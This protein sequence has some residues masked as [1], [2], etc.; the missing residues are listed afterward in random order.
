MKQVIV[1]IIVIGMTLGSVFAMSS[2]P[3][4]EIMIPDENYKVRIIDIDGV[5]TIGSFMTFEC[6]TFVSAKRGATVIFIPFDRIQSIRM[7]NNSDVITRELPEIEMT[8]TLTDGSEYESLAVSREEFT[9]QAGFGQFRIRT[10]HIRSIEFLNDA[11]VPDE[12]SGAMP[13]N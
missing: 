1:T 10:D 8:V 7:K 12:A 11:A 13:A 3:D 2:C 6:R 5:E 4:D 9:G